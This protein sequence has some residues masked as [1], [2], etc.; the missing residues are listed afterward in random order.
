[1]TKHDI[2]KD[3]SSQTGKEL[4]VLY[5][6][7]DEITVVFVIF[8]IFQVFSKISI[9]PRK[10]NSYLRRHTGRPI[11]RKPESIYKN[12]MQKRYKIKSKG[13]NVIC[14][15]S[16]DKEEKGNMT[17]PKGKR[18]CI[19]QWR[20]NVSKTCFSNIC[21]PLLTSG[22]HPFSPLPL[23]YCVAPFI[24]C[25]WN[26]GVPTKYGRWLKNCLLFQ[27][28]CHSGFSGKQVLLSAPHYLKN[29]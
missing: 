23:A 11:K 19:S 13:G 22:S 24:A 7:N 28:S 1:M 17:Q 20:L 16:T 21:L 26:L 6:L 2:Q 9:S 10:R 25:V 5:S 4:T 18:K 27:R 3:K 15:P 14:K 12:W 29:R 8:C